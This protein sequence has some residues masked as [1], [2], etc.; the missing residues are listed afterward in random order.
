MSI[1]K[2]RLAIS[3]F[4]TMYAPCQQ[5]NT[6]IAFIGVLLSTHQ[7]MIRVGTKQNRTQRHTTPQLCTSVE[8][9]TS[10]ARQHWFAARA[11]RKFRCRRD[12][13]SGFGAPLASP[14]RRVMQHLCPCT[15]PIRQLIMQSHIGRAP[16]ITAAPQRA[17]P[18]ASRLVC[19]WDLC[20][21]RSCGYRCNLRHRYASNRWFP[22]RL[23]GAC[24]GA[25]ERQ[26]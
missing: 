22:L 23:R 24:S 1:R 6:C 18:Q 10:Y 19:V 11:S 12:F 17:F 3:R 26:A 2:S 15:T 4:H 13:A 8:E 9:H 25:A 21:T 16:C 14:R 7:R 20:S 5:R